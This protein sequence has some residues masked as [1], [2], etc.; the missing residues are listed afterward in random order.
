MSRTLAWFP[1][2]NGRVLLKYQPSMKSGRKCQLE[3]PKTPYPPKRALAGLCLKRHN[4]SCPHMSSC[5]TDIWRCV[6]LSYPAFF[7][8]R[9]LPSLVVPYAMLKQ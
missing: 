5:H 6:S 8:I 3:L 4:V 9:P 2:I 7:I 1:F